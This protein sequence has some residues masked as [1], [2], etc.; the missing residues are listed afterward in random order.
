M[1]NEYKCPICQITKA[2]LE[3]LNRH[4]DE[5]HFED[6]DDNSLEN[7]AETILNW[8]KTS[9]KKTY[10]NLNKNEIQSYINNKLLNNE[11][12]DYKLNNIKKSHWQNKEQVNKCNKCK[13][14]FGLISKKL[15]CAK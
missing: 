3:A 4:L 1:N 14:N 2:N 10:S 13:K 15:N 12:E 9:S 5:K 8:I 11:K 7:P 6:D